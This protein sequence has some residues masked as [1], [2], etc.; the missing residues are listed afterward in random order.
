MRLSHLTIAL[1]FVAAIATATVAQNRGDVAPSAPAQPTASV[2][3]GQAAIDRAAAAH[4]Y[5]FIFFW[6]EKNEQ[7]DK[8]W[9]VFQAAAAKVA[10]SADVVSI[11]ITDP[12]ERRLVDRYGVSRAP[13]PL[14]L[15][16]AP[17]GAITKGLTKDFGEAELRDAFVSRSTERCMKALQSRKLVFVCVVDE[18]GPQGQATIP[19]GVEDFKADKK[20]ARATEIVLVRASDKAEA[21]LLAEMKVDPKGAK[22]VVVFLAPPGSM[23]GKFDARATKEEIVAKLV[24]AQSSCCP[25]GKC[26]PG[27]CGPQ[28]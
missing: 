9:S 11:G 18:P 19:Q 24:S 10:K 23:I 1:F 27:G 15:A 17:C 14:V 2:S 13:M 26:G 6:K 28:K 20:Y 16:V 4:K 8:V 25:G 12:A 7:T 21:D 5:A 3:K 22:P